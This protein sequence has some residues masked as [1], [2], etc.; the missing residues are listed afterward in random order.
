MEHVTEAYA[1]P[2]IEERTPIDGPLVGFGS[3]QAS[4]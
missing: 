2:A 4:G 1:A 3:G